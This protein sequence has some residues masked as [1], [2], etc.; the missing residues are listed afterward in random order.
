[1]LEVVAAVREMSV[2]ELAAAVESNT[3]RVFPE[4][5]EACR[6]KD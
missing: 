4:L 5:V 6:K 1:V 2:V 3:H